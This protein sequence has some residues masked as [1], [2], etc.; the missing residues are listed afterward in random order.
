MLSPSLNMGRDRITVRSFF[1]PEH[2]RC[3]GTDW[4]RSITPRNS[5]LPPAQ[6]QWLGGMGIVVL[7][8]AIMP[9][10]GVGGMQLYRT[11]M[12]GPLKDNKLSPR[13]ADTAKTLWLIYCALTL[14]CALAYWAAGMSFFDAISHSF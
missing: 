9:M 5:L 12:P 10:L 3:H 1:W 4:D 8:V 7:A 2:D 13:I 6:L 14:L 11:E